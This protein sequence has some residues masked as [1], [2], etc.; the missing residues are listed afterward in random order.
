MITVPQRAHAE[1]QIKKVVAV[2][3]GDFN[4]VI[5]FNCSTSEGLT[6]QELL[7]R[8]VRAAYSDRIKLSDRLTIQI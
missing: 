5:Q 7:L 8:K 1:W 4:I 3:L 6:K 2:Q